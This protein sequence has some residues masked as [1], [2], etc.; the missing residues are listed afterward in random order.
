[1]NQFKTA[2]RYF[3]PYEVD[4]QTHG[5]S[6][7]LHE[8]DGTSLKK[9]VAAF[10]LLPYITWRSPE[11]QQII[12]DNCHVLDPSSYYEKPIAVSDDSDMDTD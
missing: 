6:Y 7:K 9:N 10:Q 1:M 3:G 11:F 5:G 12:A 4:R 8:L 2:L